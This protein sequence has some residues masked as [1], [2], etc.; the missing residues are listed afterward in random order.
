MLDWM[1]LTVSGEHLLAIL[2][3]V[4]NVDWDGWRPEDGAEAGETR[5]RWVERVKVA[6]QYCGTQ[7]S[8]KV[9]IGT[10]IN[11][12]LNMVSPTEIGMLIHKDVH[13]IH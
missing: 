7:Y 3:F 12:R 13:M 1:I 5:G 9:H 8:E 6:T 4:L 10:I 2:H 11:G